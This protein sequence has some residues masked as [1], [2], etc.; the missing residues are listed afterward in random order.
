[1]NQLSLALSDVPDS[2]ID[3][4][5]TGDNNPIAI[6]VFVRTLIHQR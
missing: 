2:S 1:L 3:L 5:A 4:P 6:F